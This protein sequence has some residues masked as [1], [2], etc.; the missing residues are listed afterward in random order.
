MKIAIQFI[1]ATY[2]QDLSAVSC[3]VAYEQTKEKSAGK[4]RSL[5]AIYIIIFIRFMLSAKWRIEGRYIVC[6]NTVIVDV[7]MK[8]WAGDVSLT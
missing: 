3:N 2:A 6:A 4:S 8:F 7:F 1:E 5:S